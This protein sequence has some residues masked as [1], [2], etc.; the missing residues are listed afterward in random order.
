M[1]KPLKRATQSNDSRKNAAAKRQLE[2]DQEKN[3]L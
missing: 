3:Y 1:K 2:L